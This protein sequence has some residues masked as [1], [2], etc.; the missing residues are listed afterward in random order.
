M[1]I[2]VE[3]H[4]IAYMALPKAGCSSV[5]AALAHLDPDVTLPPEDRIDVN[6]WHAIYPTRRFRPHRW[7]QYADYWR[8]AVV[9]DPVKRLMSVYTNR[10]VEFKDLHNCRNILRGHVDLPKDPDPDFFFTHLRAYCDASSVIKH[11][12]L[13]AELFLG[14]K[15]LKY[16][17]VYRTEE[18]AELPHDLARITGTTVDLPRENS[19]DQRLAL[20]DLK[21]G[22]V[23]AI[24]GFLNDEY[25]YLSGYYDNPL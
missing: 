13:G 14:P 8:F 1:V 4:K 7:K 3:A 15:P 25:A 2:T 24:R 20:D 5:K 16:D 23:R 6:T 12:C 19:S 18:L 10:V 9:R 11:H 21:Y 22:T 17:R